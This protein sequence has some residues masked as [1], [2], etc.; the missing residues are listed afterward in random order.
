MRLAAAL[1]AA[2]ALTVAA[3]ALGRTIDV[4]P[5]KDAI[6]RALNRAEPGD[7][8]RIH[9][10][11]YRESLVVD[12][13]VDLLGAPGERRP[14]IDGRCRTQYTIAVRDPGVALRHLKVV[15]ADE[16]FGPFPAEVD[17]GGVRTGRAHGL[18][19]KDTCDAEYGINV[20]DTGPVSLVN[21]RASSFSD[22]GLYVGS[23]ED[24]GDGAIS[25]RGNESFGNNRGI[26][27]EEV[28]GGRIV[29]LRNR[30]HDNT[31]A[32]EGAPTGIWFH[33]ADGVRAIENRVTGSGELGIHLSPG[34]DGN[35]LLRNEARRNP[36]DFLNE[37]SDNCGSGNVFGSAGGYPLAP[38]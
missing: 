1:A 20:F 11:R 32:G 33:D 4:Q 35:R 29:L 12:E 28:A 8:L 24:I 23:I 21:N 6:A 19:L 15:G 38:C 16:G 30:I 2:S 5:G 22:A 26:I 13:R 9:H 27:V 10:G 7:A 14:V 37:G 31:A 25:L 3:P 36:L 17:F 18:V 34:S